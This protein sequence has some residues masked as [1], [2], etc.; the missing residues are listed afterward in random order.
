MNLVRLGRVV[1]TLR[2]RRG[3]RQVDLARRAVCSRQTV[4]LVE[5]GR[6]SR[7]SL[8]ALGRIA[9]ALESE[10][11]LSIRWHGGQLERLLDEGYAELVGAIARRLESR[12]WIVRLE[13][14]YAV[15]SERGS[16]DLLAVHPGARVLVVVE[17]KTELLSAEATARKHD[18]K[19]RLAARLAEE[20]FGWAVE[21]VS[22]L[23]VLPR[24][25]TAWRHLSRHAAVFGRLY[26][27]RGADL[28]RWLRSPSGSIGG[29]LFV[30]P[31]SPAGIRSEV[32]ARRRMRVSGATVATHAEPR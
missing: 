27:V 3:W 13:V 31:A 11:E 18:E 16:I 6:T 25:T 29:V 12:G 15:G 5:G 30:S 26:P 24:G 21:H 10:I 2:R 9:N 19:V 20:R 22:R 4:S 32:T 23:L 28:D 7:V 14:T 8:R 17:V 1:R